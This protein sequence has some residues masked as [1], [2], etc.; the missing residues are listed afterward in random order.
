MKVHKV[1]SYKAILL[2]NFLTIHVCGNPTVFLCKFLRYVLCVTRY[3]SMAKTKEQK[4]EILKS[5][6]K[7]LA[8]SK[9]VIFAKFNQ[10]T[11]K[12]NEDLRKQLKQEE[13]EYYVAKK[14]L[15]NL[16]FKD[17]KLDNF[18]I[19]NI[20]GQ[21]AAIFGYK[22]EVAP[23]RIVNEFKKTHNEKIDFVGGILENKFLSTEE[24][25]FLAELPSKQELYAKI[26]GSINAPVSGLVN[27]MAGNLR[28][29]VY[30]LK[31]IN[32]RD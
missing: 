28:S 16:I 14:T 25:Q 5:L 15:L 6:N 31:A 3:A 2:Y 24:T 7:K 27:V 13:S 4:K 17:L 9:S 19:R 10:L 21:I 32:N 18:N 29:L 1:E 20:E 12:E 23:A 22:D 11:V 8:D 30:V 26:V